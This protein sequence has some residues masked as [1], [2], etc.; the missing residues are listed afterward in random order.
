VTCYASD[1]LDRF[2]SRTN[3]LVNFLPLTPATDG[4]LNARLFARLPRGACLVNLAR[5][6]HVVD[7][8]LIA[9]LDSGQLGGAML[10]VFN[11]EPLPADHPFWKH[12][13]IIVT[14][15]VAAVTLASEAAAQVIANL[16]RLE[17]GEAPLGAVDRNLG[18]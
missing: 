4:L 17:R 15:H 7:A 9:A 11:D 3:V 13:R 14:P 18:Y 2:L 8:D 10:D 16:Q 5:G 12:P 6:G 1:D